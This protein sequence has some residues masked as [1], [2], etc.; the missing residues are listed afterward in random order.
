VYLPNCLSTAVVAGYHVKSLSRSLRNIVSLPPF[1]SHLQAWCAGYKI[2]SSKAAILGLCAMIRDKDRWSHPC[3]LSFSHATKDSI[4]AVPRAGF[5]LGHM[6]LPPP[7]LIPQPL[8]PLCSHL[9]QAWPGL[10]SMGTPGPWLGGQCLGGELC[11]LEGMS[12]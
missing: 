10:C 5:A 12:H 7:S 2:L 1:N 11:K 8:L 9:A 6:T 3:R 4:D